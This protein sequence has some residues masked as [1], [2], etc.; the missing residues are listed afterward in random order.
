MSNLPPT[1][2]YYSIEQKTLELPDGSSIAYLGRRIVPLPERFATLE[3]HVVQQG[4]RPDQIAYKHLGDA[5]QFWRICDANA[6]LHPDELTDRPG[7]RIRI[8]LPEGVPGPA[9]A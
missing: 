9:N 7:E 4:E 5:E 2:R 8:T 3:E 6:V 1:S